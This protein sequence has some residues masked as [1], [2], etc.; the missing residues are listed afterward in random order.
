[1]NNMN[2]VLRKN[3]ILLSLIILLVVALIINGGIQLFFRTYLKNNHTQKDK[4]VVTMIVE[5]LDDYYLDN[6]EVRILNQMSE[7]DNIY[8]KVESAE[9]LIYRT[10]NMGMMGN[11]MMG[12][13]W[14]NNNNYEEDNYNYKTYDMIIDKNIIGK[15]YIGREHEL[16]ISEEDSNFVWG[17]NALFIVVLLIAFIIVIF[18]SK[19]LSEKISRPIINI[20]NGTEEITK[21]KYKNIT[22]DK[23]D[24]LEL[25][26]LAT[27][28]EKLANKLDEQ[29]NLRKRMT[30]DI[31]HE[32]RSPLAVLRSQ[33]EAMI[34]GVFEPNKERLKKCHMETIR[35]TKLIDDLNELTTVESGLNKL[36]L[37]KISINDLL[38]E[39]AMSFN[40]LYNKKNIQLHLDL[41]PD[42]YIIGD[43]EQLN[44]AIINILTN[45]YK[46]SN[47]DSEVLVSTKFLDSE[48]VLISIKDSGIGIEEKDLPYIFERFYRSDLSRNRE[49]GGA[50]VGLAIVKSIV[51][52]HKGRIEVKSKIG[53]GSEFLIYLK[54]CTL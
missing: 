35:L 7:N 38:K 41:G 39:I 51:D 16:I 27:S 17:I 12:G 20:K 43:K 44:R 31:A 40:P 42:K 9:G 49:T 11:W 2:Q 26:Q 18:V 30:T 15:V 3:L 22:I 21:G 4:K 54:N 37:I 23:S 24:T 1:M 34:D 6:S 13:R 50:G 46:Y 48:E 14:N 45:A 36:N 47:E 28:V 10:N 25:N 5:M 32:L 53:E 19:Y 29:E 52:A 8:I 33:I